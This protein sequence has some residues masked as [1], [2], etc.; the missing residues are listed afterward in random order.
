MNGVWIIIGAAWT[1]LGFALA[2]EISR[3][4]PCTEQNWKR[5]ALVIAMCGPLVWGVCVVL[6]V[7]GP[8]LNAVKRYLQGGG[9]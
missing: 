3:Q 1:V 8:V 5:V 6:A 7:G 2:A 4:V 9:E